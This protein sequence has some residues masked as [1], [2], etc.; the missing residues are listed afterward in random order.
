MVRGNSGRVLALDPAHAPILIAAAPAEAD[1][2]ASPSSFRCFAK[3]LIRS[4]V[5][6]LRGPERNKGM[7][8]SKSFLATLFLVAAFAVTCWQPALAA[9]KKAP[10]AGGVKTQQGQTLSVPLQCSRDS[11]TCSCTGNADC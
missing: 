10:G 5:C 1:A 11:G 9:D 2:P 4:I 8:T 3:L 6:W 7:S